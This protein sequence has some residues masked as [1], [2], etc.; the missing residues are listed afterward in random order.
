MSG[1]HRPF[2]RRARF[3]APA[4]ALLL[5]AAVAAPACK[6][7]APRPPAVAAPAPPPDV[8]SDRKLGWILRLEQQRTLRDPSLPP[9]GASPSPPP[10]A[11]VGAAPAT[12]SIAGRVFAPAA[13]P[14]L[15][16]LA[17][18]PDTGIRA[19]ATVAIGRVGDPA[20]VAPLTSALG[21]TE[22]AVRV[23][24]AFALGLVG[25]KEA[26]TPL[27]AA[28]VDP[29]PLVRVRAVD[30]LGL[31]GDA[32]TAAAVAG[33]A[34]DCAARLAPIAP[35]DEEW[36]KTPEVEIC[37][38]ALFALVRLKQYDALARV[39][40]D[41]QGQ[42][43]SRWWPVAYALQR[44]ADPRAAPALLT[45]VPTDGVYTPAFALRGLAAAGDRRVLPNAIAMAV[46]QST[47][48]RLRV[49]AIRALGQIGGAEG[50]MPLLSLLN[51]RATPPTL[52]LEAVTALG[53]LRDRRAFNA[54]LDRWTDPWPAMRVA[55]LS[56]ASRIDP[57]AFSLAVSSLD[58]DPDWS[59]RAAFSGILATLPA[60]RVRSAVEELAADA[61]V[62]VR[63]PA[64]DALARLGVPDLDA[65]LFGALEA[66]DF[67]VR[68][69]AARLI[70][71]RKPEGG[72]A[73]LAAAYERG[74]SDATYDAR[75]SAIEALAQYGGAE[76]A[77]V[78][79]RALADP[80]WPV[81]WRAA[82]LA[83]AQG[84][85]PAEWIRPGPHR[86][87]DDVFESAAVLHPPY[88]PHAFLETVRGTIEIE[89][90]VVDAPLTT[91]NFIELARAGFFNGLKVHR[92][93]PNFVIQTGDPRGDGEGGPG[94]TIRD[95][96]S[97]QPFVRGTVGMALASVRD[98]GGSQFFIALSPQ[99]HLDGK[100]T[101]FGRVIRGFEFLDQVRQ[102][103]VIQQVKI[104]DG[105][106]MK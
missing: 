1:L 52:A 84:R 60:D 19:R 95:E 30:A 74:L 79:T 31:L 85:P 14:D 39:A 7:A 69:A 63:G 8:P 104:W 81:R 82:E 18:D 16:R 68:S 90:N 93:V 96:L 99:P 59:V 36:P 56:G 62:R 29:S 83:R 75:L 65:R 44:I 45:L 10:P 78:L 50:V 89:L 61:D 91:R 28:L 6:S 23:Q 25:A 55:A 100:Y 22:E 98:T 20:G 51:Q 57:D 40:L 13:E 103:D 47:D 86:L 71:D 97:P 70:G 58:R 26:S 2:A 92:L 33:A 35:D 34:V 48:V 32:S 76:A 41:A 9:R 38:S 66:A 80:E 94:Y 27:V 24:A 49:T 43:V 72:A 17:L 37:R 73:K 105:V 15:E 54:L 106:V 21:D 77:E 3:A 64:L 12:R 88:S 102:G 46:N 67:G 87:A 42:P 11:A 4:G 53:A 101:V 5:I